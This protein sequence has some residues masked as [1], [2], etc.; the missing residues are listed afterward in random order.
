[1][2]LARAA[3]VAALWA[4]S[5]RGFACPCQGSSG[6]AAGVTTASDR[7]GASLTETTRFVPG[8]WRANGLY[9]SLGPG[10]HQASEDVTA[11]VG[12]RPIVPLELSLETAV[13][14]ESFA[15]PFFHEERTALGDTTLRAR[16]DAI[17]EP[18]PYER[19]RIPWPSVTVLFS[20]RAPTSPAGN[21]DSTGA[22]SGTTGSVGSSS[23]SEGLGAWEPS[24]G[25]AFV[26][27]LDERWQVSAYLEAAYRF[28]DTY[29]HR[30]RHLGPR[31]FAQAGARFAPTPTTGIGVLTDY[32]WE[33][34]VS[35]EGHTTPDTSQRIWGIGA[36]CYLRAEPSRLRWGA[37][38]HYSPPFDGVSKNASQSTSVAVSLGYVF[39]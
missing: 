12:Y 34:D 15:S 39:L 23:T 31:V 11:I 7:I 14:H 27:T 37:L 25:G 33:G 13:G 30:D 1:M 35:Y 6:P 17:D 24:I 36:F 9:G 10:E 29:I 2:R 5:S 38:V 18:M 26:R 21:S 16:W 28:S 4:T 19:V 20:L 22:F 8:A 3:L 32:G